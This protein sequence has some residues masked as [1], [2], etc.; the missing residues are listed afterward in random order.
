MLVR[1]GSTGGNDV[2][3]TVKLT[4]ASLGDLVPDTSGSLNGDFHVRGS[5]PAL[6]ITG[7]AEGKALAFA[8]NR[9]ARLHVDASVAIAAGS[10]GQGGTAR[11]RGCRRGLRV[12]HDHRERLGQPGETCVEVTAASERLNGSLAAAGGLN[13]PVN[14][15]PGEA[16]CGD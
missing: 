8:E 3:A 16:N 2:D 14:R 13:E 9:I 12:R 5:W 4:L 11:D 15:W 6:K 10:H 7:T 1:G